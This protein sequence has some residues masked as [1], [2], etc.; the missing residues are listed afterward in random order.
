MKAGRKQQTWTDLSKVMSSRSG[1]AHSSKLELLRIRSHYSLGI[2]TRSTL[3][4][5]AQ[6]YLTSLSGHFLG[7]QGVLSCPDPT[8][9]VHEK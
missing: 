6:G 3:G 4:S 7:D 5:H 8:E 2:A 1:P 9:H